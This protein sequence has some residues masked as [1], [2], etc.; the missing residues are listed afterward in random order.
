LKNKGGEK[1]S[2]QDKK[3]R[4]LIYRCLNLGISGCQELSEEHGLKAIEIMDRWF[5]EQVQTWVQKGGK[6]Y[7]PV[8]LRGE[9]AAPVFTYT[10]EED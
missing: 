4:D 8:E 3:E 1:M 2:E 6:L 10:I 5:K 7:P 9:D